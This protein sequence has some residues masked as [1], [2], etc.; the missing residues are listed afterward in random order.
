[1]EEDYRL[2]ELCERQLH[3]AHFENNQTMCKVCNTT[4]M[5]LIMF[6]ED[7][8][9]EYM[10]IDNIDETNDK[11]IDMENYIR[12]IRIF[13]T[14]KKTIYFFKKYNNKA[15]PNYIINMF[16]SQLFFYD[17]QVEH[18]YP[19]RYNVV[20]FIIILNL[21]ERFE[22]FICT[23]SA[24]YNKEHKRKR[25]ESEPINLIPN[26]IH[27]YD[28]DI[29]KPPKDY[30]KNININVIY[31][32]LMKFLFSADEKENIEN[33]YKEFLDKSRA[34]KKNTFEKD[35]SIFL[36]N[37]ICQ[38]DPETRR[39]ILRH[40]L[41]SILLTDLRQY[42]VIEN[43]ITDKTNRKII[44]KFLGIKSRYKILNN[45]Q[46]IKYRDKV[47]T[48]CGETTI[49]N[50]L[51]YYF[52]SK[53]G[54]IKID[55]SYSPSI[56]NFY[57]K[58]PSIEAQFENIEKTTLDWLDVVSELP[59]TSIYSVNG[60]ILPNYTNVS[61]VVKTIL[62][63]SKN[64]LEDILT[65]ITIKEKDGMYVIDNNLSLQ[66]RNEHAEIRLLDKDYS[67]DYED[68][69]QTDYFIYMYNNIYKKK[70]Y[71]DFTYDNYKNYY[72]DLDFFNL[73]GNEE[74]DNDDLNEIDKEKFGGFK[75][76]E[77]IIKKEQ[78]NEYFK[79][80]DSL[81]L[82]GTDYT[83]IDFLNKFHSLKLL[84]LEFNAKLESLEIDFPSS[85]LEEIRLI[86]HGKIEKLVIK[87]IKSLKIL[88]IVEN[89]SLDTVV[90]ENLEK[91]EELIIYRNESLIFLPDITSFKNLQI[92]KLDTDY[93]FIPRFDKIEKLKNLVVINRYI[94]NIPYMKNLESLKLFNCE[95]LNNVIGVTKLTNLKQLV[96]QNIPI[97]EIPDISFLKELEILDMRNSFKIFERFEGLEKL[98]QLRIQGIENLISIPDMSSLKNL[99]GLY[100]KFNNSLEKLKGLENLNNLESLDISNN[101]KLSE[102]PDLKNLK[103]LEYLTICGNIIKEIIISDYLDNLQE[104]NIKNNLFLAKIPN[105]KFFRN[106]EYFNMYGNTKVKI[107]NGLNGLNLLEIRISRTGIEFIPEIKLEKLKNLYIK[108]ND[109]LKEIFNLTLNNLEILE[110]QDN[111]KLK[112]ISN[113][114]CKNLSVLEIDEENLESIGD[115]KFSENIKELKIESR[116][117]IMRRPYTKADF[118]KTKFPKLNTVF[119]KTKNCDL[120]LIASFFRK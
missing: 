46:S 120:S 82:F 84:S 48:T 64:K 25:G 5:S 73:I 3:I 58:Y 51:N 106:L 92:L 2:C 37:S 111:N 10:I 16:I 8:F 77:E 86:K 110:I 117:L 78:N 49:L 81:V 76:T 27:C 62:N 41:L 31:E 56:N 32:E 114:E 91:L 26:G 96:F 57:K 66:L 60:D 109:N 102:I 104:L 55:E 88:K 36:Y 4:L 14:I 108:E 39:Y 95:E 68:R 90:L 20:G 112:T 54:T 65:K 72:V 83:N 74:E 50:L 101:Y 44:D 118:S 105:M 24:I 53:D 75:I 6:E 67:D 103:K 71:Y 79:Y 99:K 97:R 47:F 23:V 85:I 107:I 116:S 59:N 43:R 119:I 35:M 13:S 1:M 42:I 94:K 19:K 9:N 11:M 115:I 100:I 80:M 69:K 34:A 22:E 98:M 12:N 17:N 38:I 45:I 28:K 29:S 70:F 18:I 7:K 40:Y 93:E 61:Y 21:Y 87:N 33:K 30:S 52:M 113:I 89:D 15:D 63:S